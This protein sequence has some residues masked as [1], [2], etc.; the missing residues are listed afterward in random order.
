V[1]FQPI[2]RFTSRCVRRVPARSHLV[3]IALLVP[4]LAAL[5]PVHPAAAQLV[6]TAV[7]ALTVFGSAETSAPAA[8][9][10]VQLLIGQ[11][12]REFG[13]DRDG[14]GGGSWEGGSGV[15]NTLTLVPDPSSAAATPEGRR[16]GRRPEQPQSITAAQLAPIVDAV[17][18]TAGI[19][20][21]A[22]QTNFSPLATEPFGRRAKNARLDFTIEQPTPEGLTALIAAASDAAAANGLVVQTAGVQYNPDDCDTIEE[23]AA[24]AAIA[25][26]EARAERL[27]RLLGVTIGDVVAA[28]TD[29]FAN[30]LPDEGGCKGQIS[31]SYDSRDGGIGRSL[32]LFDPALPAEVTV[33]SSLTVSYEIVE[34]AAD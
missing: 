26:A 17:A 27:S 10:T 18:T 24:Q 31:Y 33:A 14:S 16:R 7:P 23:Q 28:T 32:P 2:P 3:A 1:V 13:F 8:T 30:G 11:G 21:E 12:D 25:D 20:P 19:A 15:E 22:V 29:P 6:A 5:A 34:N 9:A 4:S